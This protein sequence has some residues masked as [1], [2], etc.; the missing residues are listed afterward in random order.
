MTQ[1]LYWT[2]EEWMKRVVP[3]HHSAYRKR[4]E[5]QEDVRQYA[6]LRFKIDQ[7]AKERSK[8]TSLKADLSKELKK[9]AKKLTSNTVVVMT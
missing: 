2:Q 8:L 9:V 3:Y 4:I 7:I 1:A 6:Y 5:E